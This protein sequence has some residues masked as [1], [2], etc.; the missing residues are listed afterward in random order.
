MS[1]FYHEIV[2][3][4]L[5]GWLVFIWLDFKGERNDVITGAWFETETDART[6]VTD[7][8]PG[9]REYFVKGPVIDPDLLKY[10]SC[11]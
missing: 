7:E 1:Q 2:P 8:Y 4:A 6:F 5:E 9:S 10:R 3:A 11:L